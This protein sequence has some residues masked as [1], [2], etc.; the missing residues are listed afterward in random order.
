MKFKIPFT[1]SGIEVL[2]KRSKPYSR[3][4]RGKRRGKLEEQLK[5][6]DA[7][8]NSTEYMGVC[9]RTL[10]F[11]FLFLLILFTVLL[12]FAKIKMF[13]LFGFGIA[14][15]FSVFIT[16][17]QYTYPRI[18]SF[19]KSRD[20]E[21]NLISSLQD[22]LVQLESGVPIYD[23]ITNIASSDYGFVSSEFAKAVKSINSGLSQIEA[24]EDLIKKNSSVYFK[25]V[26]WQISN[27]MRSGSD[28]G[29][30]IKDSVDILNKEQAIQIQSYGSK[31]NPL[32]MFY[33]LLAVIIPSLG[34][35]FF[36]IISSM[37]GL[38]EIVI[39]LLFAAV[40]VIIVI[41]QVMF[42]GL[43]KSRR[44]SLL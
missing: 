35:A 40:F 8:I 7:N 29:I 38:S 27:G 19:K 18:Y 11:S 13:Y 30:V 1:L 32:I 42:L 22:M 41:M 25:R 31:L 3:F 26:L 16:L 28:M 12:G 17:R 10:I 20:I 4:F 43:I 34:V 14:L 36:T 6:C 23:I 15:V 9:F 5:S 24:L 33:M 44:P 21:R 2:K 39:K 37:I